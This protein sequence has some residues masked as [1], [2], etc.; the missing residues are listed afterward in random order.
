M[1]GVIDIKAAQAARERENS[2]RSGG[3]AFEEMAKERLQRIT[4]NAQH[5]DAHTYFT[6]MQA[7]DAALQVAEIAISGK[8]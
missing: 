4:A 8:G 5:A 1:T 3:R 7:I 2:L 6:V